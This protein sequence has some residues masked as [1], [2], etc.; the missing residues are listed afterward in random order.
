ME[1]SFTH[2]LAFEDY[3]KWLIEIYYWRNKKRL[4]GY[5]A[6]MLLGVLLIV[7][8]LTNAFGLSDRYP[9]ETLY[10]L[11]SSFVITPVL[12]YIGVIR[13]SKKYF[14]S[15]PNLYNDVKYVFDEEKIAYESYDGNTGTCKWQNIKSI[16][17]DAIFIRI[18]MP[19]DAAFL[20][21]KSKMDTQ[22]LKELQ[23]LL[24]KIKNSKTAFEHLN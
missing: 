5:I 4:Y 18:T 24:S 21:V 15:N 2:Q 10:L 17:E 7:F 16:E 23:H 14:N 19:T 3:K 20:I 8:K 22:K 6:M 12:F 1:I 9:E 13:N 11:G